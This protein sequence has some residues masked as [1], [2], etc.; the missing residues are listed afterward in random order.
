MGLLNKVQ[1]LDT[2]RHVYFDNLYSS[3]ELLNEMFYRQ[4]YAYG[5]VRNNRKNLPEAVLKAKVKPG[6]SLFRCDGP[7]L[8]LN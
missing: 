5:T 2:G 3:P 1:H 7:M 4:T 8:A 6:E